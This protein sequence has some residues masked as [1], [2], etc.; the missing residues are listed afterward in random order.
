VDHDILST[1]SVV[2]QFSY[3]T[4]ISLNVLERK[5]KRKLSK[6]VWIELVV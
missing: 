6:K 2:I 5:L 1:V 3:H 4:L